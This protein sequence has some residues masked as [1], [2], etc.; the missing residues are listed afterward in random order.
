LKLELE[1]ISESL[2]LAL[3]I[4][5]S[6]TYLLSDHGENGEKID[7][8]DLEM[9]SITIEL[10]LPDEIY[11]RGIHNLIHIENGFK[12]GPIFEAY[13]N[14]RVL[15]EKLDT[16]GVVR[17]TD[18]KIY[19]LKSYDLGSLEDDESLLYAIA[20]AYD[21]IKEVRGKL[22]PFAKERGFL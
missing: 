20:K 8:E 13:Q 22:D 17:Q 10:A 18:A 2:Q 19:R 4:G 5:K 16:K 3:R 14:L 6:R 7:E 15:H 12:I 1:S 11:S 9:S 21:Q